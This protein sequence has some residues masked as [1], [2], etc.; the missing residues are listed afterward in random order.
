[1]D[2]R[3]AAPGAET[4]DEE[5][6][7]GVIRSLLATAL[8]ALRTRLDLAA[9]E[10]E[11]YLLRTVHMLVWAVAAIACGL[12]ALAFGL[13]ALIVALW[14]T[15]RMAGLLGG[16]LAFVALTAAF[17]SFGARALRNRPRMLEGT[18]QQ[19]EHD[20]RRAGDTG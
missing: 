15:H 8:D 2:E 6:R 19:L 20:Q 17:A 1:M 5:A 14:D 11:I 10:V 4:A 9:V 18:L 3:A 7:N 12:L 16:T 13:V